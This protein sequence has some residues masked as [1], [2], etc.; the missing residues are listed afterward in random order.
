MGQISLDELQA[1][2]DGIPEEEEEEPSSNLEHHNDDS[3]D[4]ETEEFVTDCDDIPHETQAKDQE[5]NST[6]EEITLQT[7]EAYQKQGLDGKNEEGPAES[8]QE[9]AVVL[10]PAQLKLRDGEDSSI[11]FTQHKEEAALRHSLLPDEDGSI[12]KTEEKADQDRTVKTE[13]VDNV[14]S[15]TTLL[16]I[17]GSIPLAHNSNSQVNTEAN[18]SRAPESFTVERHLLT[19]SPKCAPLRMSHN[20]SLGVSITNCKQE[21]EPSLK[22]SEEVR[23]PYGEMPVLENE[24]LKEEMQPLGCCKEEDQSDQDKEDETITEDE[25]NRTNQKHEEGD[26]IKEAGDPRVTKGK[27]LN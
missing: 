1:R 22:S 3:E 2:V 13:I 4:V 21:K 23:E 12:R 24:Y 27:I 25:E 18:N 6:R 26:G 15:E 20:E 5:E 7:K 19:L 14:Q 9:Q 8:S 17:K 11:V 16:D 10:L